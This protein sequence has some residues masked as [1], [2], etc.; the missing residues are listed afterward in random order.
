MQ[1]IEKLN[2]NSLKV[3]L[4]FCKNS[5]IQIGSRTYSTATKVEDKNRGIYFLSKFDPSETVR[6]YLDLFSSKF[7][8][9]N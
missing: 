3:L 9:L 4:S 8:L 6:K 1:Q 7:P 5:H 2:K